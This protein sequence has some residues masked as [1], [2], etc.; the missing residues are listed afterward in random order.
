MTI[1]LFVFV[2]SLA[3]FFFLRSTGLRESIAKSYIVL[4][5]LI[6]GSTETL[7]F[8]GT[9][10]YVAICLFWIALSALSLIF[11][12]LLLKRKNPR[13]SLENWLRVPADYGRHEAI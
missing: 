9:I 3:I 13:S 2:I 8:F 7:S 1:F 11:V 6:A 4:F 12:L 10:T 5:L